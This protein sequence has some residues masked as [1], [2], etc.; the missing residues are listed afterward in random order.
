LSLARQL[1]WAPAMI[2]TTHFTSP[3]SRSVGAALALGAAV[4]ACS[5]PDS[6]E[7]SPKIELDGVEYPLARDDPRAIFA[8]RLEDYEPMVASPTRGSGSVEGPPRM[9]RRN[10]QTGERR[11]VMLPP[12]VQA[13]LDEAKRDGLSSELRTSGTANRAE[14]P[15]ALGSLLG[16]HEP[17]QGLMGERDALL[18]ARPATR[19]TVLDLEINRTTAYSTQTDTTAWPVRTTVH[20]ALTFPG[21]KTWCSGTMIGWRTVLTAGHC[22]KNAQYGEV[23]SVRVIPGLEGTYM[24]FGESP[25]Y[26]TMVDSAWAEDYD[27]DFDWGLVW[28]TRSLG[29]VT[30]S[31]GVRAFSDSELHNLPIDMFGYPQSIDAFGRQMVRSPGTAQCSDGEMVYYSATA[32][33]GLSGAGVRPSSG[34]LRDN[35]LAVHSGTQPLGCFTVNHKGGARITTLRK[36]FINGVTDSNPQTSPDYSRWRAT[37]GYGFSRVSAAASDTTRINYIMRGLDNAVWFNS[38]F[39]TNPTDF[40]WSS[41]GGDTRGTPVIVARSSPN[42]DIF[43]RGTGIPGI[44]CH[45]RWVGVWEPSQTGWNCFND[46]MIQGSPTAVSTSSGR[47]FVY[48]RDANRHVLEKRWASGTGWQ[49][50]RDLG[51]TTNEDVSVAR[52]SD[53]SHALAIRDVSGAICT[54]T[55]SYSPSS[56]YCIPNSYTTVAPTIVSSGPSRLDIFAPAE[57]GTVLQYWWRGNGWSGPVSIGGK[58]RLPVVAVSR[59]ANKIDIVVESIPE[60]NTSGPTIYKS[61]DGDTWSPSQI[62]YDNLTGA[63]IDVSAAAWGSG[64]LEVFARGQDLRI[65][66]RWVT[67]SGWAP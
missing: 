2:V 35:L 42:F 39:N 8:D 15:E 66:N 57:D 60:S 20:L 43:A 9:I 3:L 12:D 63:M 32:S 36:A 55:I 50:V 61:L 1:H 58:T 14:L 62:G 10:L 18:E 54:V 13:A 45:K 64:R 4:S 25:S 65:Y 56:W 34:S 23:D 67:S 6:S 26:D 22:L 21:V 24:P 28:M 31:L 49:A 5:S 52:M 48:G 46:M 33:G 11:V 16:P 53:T 47:L 37:N 51:V 38:R 17:S 19:G 40:E 7:P 29:E 27:Y 44:V 59:A 30:G 41:L